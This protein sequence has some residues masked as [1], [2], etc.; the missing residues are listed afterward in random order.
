MTT[1]ERNQMSTLPGLC[2]VGLDLSLVSPCMAIYDNGGWSLYCFQQLRK[3]RELP[4]IITHN[5]LTIHIMPPIPNKDMD[6]FT[7]YKH[8]VDSFT[9]VVRLRPGT[10]HTKIEGY[11]FAATG[12]G[13]A[14]KLHEL[15]GIIAYTLHSLSNM[16]TVAFVPPTQWKK[17][18]VNSGFASKEMVVERV[19]SDLGVDLYQLMNR[20]RGG[21]KVPNPIQDMADAVGLIFPSVQQMV[22][23]KE[24]NKRKK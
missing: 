4:P 1:M 3:D 6:R 2:Y 8:I 18:Y 22:R 21:K 12:Q 23:S 13:S 11:G 15:S 16:S 20:K 9:Q 10:V 19:E 14:Y 24:Q 17:L 5:N 7:R